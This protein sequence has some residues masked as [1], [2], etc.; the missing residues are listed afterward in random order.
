MRSAFAAAASIAAALL[1]FASAQTYSDCNPMNSSQFPC[2]ANTGLN[3]A[4][5]EI[6]FTKGSNQSWSYISPAVKYGA[7]G[8]EFT[9][10]KRGEAPTIKTD[11]YIWYGRVEVTMKAAPGT[12]IISSI[13]IES[14]DLDEIDWEFLG[15]VDS[16]VQTN[17][18]GKGNT[19]SYDRMQ[20]FDVATP[21]TT[22]HTYA[23][24]WTKERVQWIID[25]TV[26]RTLN[27]A[28]A[29]N[30]INFPQTPS[31][32]RLGIW[33]GGDKANGAGTISWAGGQTTYDSAAGMPW[34]M[35][36]EK[37]KITNYNPGAAYNYSD[38]TGSSDSIKIVSSAAADAAGAAA[39]PATNSSSGSGLK[40]TPSGGAGIG[41]NRQ[42]ESGSSLALT[43]S[44]PSSSCPPIVKTRTVTLAPGETAPTTTLTLAGTPSASHTLLASAD[45]NQNTGSSA[46]SVGTGI[47]TLPIPSTGNP[48][49]APTPL[50]DGGSS[51]A[52]VDGSTM[53]PGSNPPPLAT[54]TPQTSHYT[55]AAVPRFARACSLGGA[56]V[57]VA[58]AA[59]V[60]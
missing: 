38:T 13:V 51:S 4:T 50:A 25:G 17:Y 16:A 24:D 46:I 11:F 41:S 43:G 39:S 6:D 1:P 44:L 31:N 42:G 19:T 48:A 34:S 60:V 15:G 21:Q 29:N 37:V 26:V 55:G 59:L 57:A 33:A 18:F 2:K 20:Q 47:L 22:A 32:V 23:V 5:Y 7:N 49:L 52:M 53:T 9:I 45:S 10:T 35:Y 54:P 36:V 58:A 3:T 14:D 40:P 8:A 28:D 30:G 12:G 27:Y 56:V